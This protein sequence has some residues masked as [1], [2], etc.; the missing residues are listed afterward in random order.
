MK[1]TRR[2]ITEAVI[3][4]L[5]AFIANG[6]VK[7][8]FDVGTGHCFDFADAVVERLG[9]PPSLWTIEYANYTAANSEGYASGVFDLPT[10]RKFRVPLPSGVAVDDLNRVD[11]GF[12]GT[13]AFVVWDGPQGRKIYFDAE[14]PEGVDSPFLLPFAKR[15]LADASG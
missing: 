9:A 3:A 5:D 1:L 14:T 12:T 11:L 8:A 13:H 15:Y 4:T 2:Q 6:T 10:L 7:Q